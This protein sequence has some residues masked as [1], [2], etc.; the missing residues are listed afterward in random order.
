MIRMGWETLP[1][2]ASW[3]NNRALDTFDLVIVGAGPGGLFAAFRAQETPGIR[4]L[5]V[6][7]GLDVD[8]RLLARQ[9]R[10][11]DNEI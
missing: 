8:G 6:D 10:P 9:N 2:L 5:I 3:A 11:H 7:E 4:V 1:P